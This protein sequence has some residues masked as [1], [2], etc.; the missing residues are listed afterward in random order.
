MSKSGD[1]VV[2]EERKKLAVYCENH[3]IAAASFVETCGPVDLEQIQ[4]IV[5][6]QPHL[7][8]LREPHFSG[9]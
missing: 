1:S 7:P 3:G 8:E 5:R 9:K 6:E 4:R 2:E